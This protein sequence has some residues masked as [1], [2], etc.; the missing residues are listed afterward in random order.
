MPPPIQIE[1][2]DSVPYNRDGA[3]RMFALE[4]LYN[5]GVEVKQIEVSEVAF[6]CQE[7]RD[8]FLLHS[9]DGTKF[10][11]LAIGASINRMYNAGWTQKQIAEDRNIT[12]NSVNNFIDAYRLPKTIKRW[13]ADGI[14]SPTLAL[15]QVRKRGIEPTIKAIEEAIPRR[16]AELK[17]EEE[18]QRQ[19]EEDK[20][21]KNEAKNSSEVSEEN[22]IIEGDAKNQL[23][24][25]GSDEV[26][27]AP[28]KLDGGKFESASDRALIRPADIKPKSLPKKLAETFHNS[29]LDLV[30]LDD[31]E[32]FWRDEDNNTVTLTLAADEF[33]KLLAM[34]Q[35]SIQ[36]DNA[37]IERLGG[38]VID[39]N[40]L[41][42][43][44]EVTPAAE[45]ENG[46]PL[47]N[48]EMPSEVAESSAA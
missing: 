9:Q 40:T 37:N 19:K 34:R 21:L 26:S 44:S 18:A 32:R 4:E 33:Q 29:L 15:E 41:E 23:D 31:E 20:R 10:S 27:N 45:A 47:G 30:S 5:E 24:I 46:S 36:F 11:Y 25:P 17:K 6:D 39:V 7:Q 48:A 42:E 28:V 12:V 8:R 1:I 22:G 2:I 16:M 38:S 35:A 43:V 14:I 13:I 3:S